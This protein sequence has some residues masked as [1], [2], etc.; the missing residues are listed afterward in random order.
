MNE[1]PIPESTLDAIGAALGEPTI[2]DVY[3]MYRAA[4]H[5]AEVAEAQLAAATTERDD[6]R[7]KFRDLEHELSLERGQVV[8]QQQRAEELEAENIKLHGQVEFEHAKR[9]VAEYQRERALSYADHCYNAGY[10]GG[11]RIPWETYLRI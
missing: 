9:V 4:I 1:Q 2:E 11:A 3:T 5:R 6:Y 7:S 8:A 10:I